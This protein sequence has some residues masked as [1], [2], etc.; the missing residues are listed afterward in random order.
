MFHSKCL[1]KAD[2][3]FMTDAWEAK[4]INPVSGSQ[5]EIFSI[6][7]I[8]LAFDLF[9][10]WVSEV[11]KSLFSDRWLGLHTWKVG[12]GGKAVYL[13]WN[14]VP[15]EL[16]QQSQ[17][18]AKANIKL[19]YSHCLIE[20]YHHHMKA[21]FVFPLLKASS[22]V[23]QRPESYV[24]LKKRNLKSNFQVVEFDSKSIL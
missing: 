8:G 5:N 22:R 18:E 4:E 17:R 24:S 20:K 1:R 23:M 3:C 19:D 16:P 21:R 2:T 14:S 15:L 13:K 6:A 7:Q 10:C 11:L 9:H 12:W